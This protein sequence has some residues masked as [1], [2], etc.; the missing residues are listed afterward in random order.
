VANSEHKGTNLTTVIKQ[1]QIS[2]ASK[3]IAK[4]AFASNDPKKPL[5]SYIC[6]WSQINSCLTIGIFEENEWKAH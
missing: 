4:F 6:N 3:E 1:R 2:M 5:L